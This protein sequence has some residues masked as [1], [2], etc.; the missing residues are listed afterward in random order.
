MLGA[1]RL[2]TVASRRA[3]S[4][5]VRTGSVGAKIRSYP[6]VTPEKLGSAAV[7]QS[8][9]TLATGLSPESVAVPKQSVFAAL[10]TFTRRHVGP[11]PATVKHMLEAL[12]F[13]DMDSFIAE[14]VPQ[15]IR[16]SE[17]AVSEHGEDAIRALSEQELLRRAK[18]LGLKNKVYRS[19]IGMGY[20]QAVSSDQRCINVL[21]LIRLI[22]NRFNDLDQVLPPV[23]LRNMLYVRPRG[24]THT[25]IY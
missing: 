5:K 19:F 25:L 9:R 15:S 6:S 20:H 1:L 4:T 14:C 23:I 24:T 3:I 8:R 22:P 18:E 17:D 2:R 13:K 12:G 21:R 11:Q 16:L 7:Q 10:D